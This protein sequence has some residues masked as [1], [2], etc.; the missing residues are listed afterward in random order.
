M[1]K[2]FQASVINIMFIISIQASSLADLPEIKYETFTLDNG[3]TV[4]VHEDKKVP[5]V[6]VN[7]WYHV[8]SKN[9]KLGKTGFAHL[10]EHLMFNGTEN[11]NN[12]YFEPF[13][14]IGSTDQNGTTNS[15]RTNYFQNVPTNALDLALWMESDRMGH[16]LGVVDQEKLDE[17]RGVVQNEKRQGENQPYGKA[18]TRIS[19]SAFPNGHP[20]SWSTIG[21]MDDLD[22]ASLEDVQDWFKTYY[23]PNNAV[24]ALAGD[25]DLETAKLKVAKYFG[26]IASG[27]PLVKPEK[28]IAKRSEEKR[29]V[30]FD[31]VPQARIY[32]IWNVPERDTE[33]AAHF[34][35][36]SSVLVGGKNSPLYKELVYEQQIATSVSSFYYDREIAGMFFIVAD[37]VAGVD[38][39][40]VETAM[41]DVMAEF[42]KRGPNPKLLKAE[43]TKILAGFIRGI[44]RIGGFGGKSDLLA[45]CQ[46]YTGD[47]GC[48]QKNLAYLDAVTPSKMK[49]TFAKW[50]DDTPYVL[51]ILPTDKYSVGE[52]DLDR[53]SGVPYPTEKVEFQFPTLQT[54]TLSNGAKV[55]LAQR[56]GVPLV[57]MNFQ[58][59]FG[60]AQENND[61]LG[62][63]NFMM[64]MLNEGTKKY[65]SLEFDEVLDSL[66]SNL[67][68]GS[69]LDT[70]VASLSSLK[71]NLSQTLDLAKEALINPTFPEKEIERIK[72]E[73]LAGIIQ[74]ENRPASIAYRNI[75]KL[76]YGE[77]HP[78]GKP[79]TGSGISETISSITRANIIDVHSRAINSAHLTFAVAGDIEMQELVNLLESKFGDWSANS[80]SDLKA[81]T[82]VELPENR[83]I[84]LIDK[85]N[86]QQS[87]I[88][89]GQ[90]LPPSATDEEI[91]IDYMNYAIGGSFT[92]RLNM[93][94]REDKS[95]S[96]GVRT[97]LGDAK[98]QR[99]MLV[100][101]PVQTDKTS[102]SMAEIVTEYADYLSTKPITQDELAKGKA[103]KT[104]RLPGQFETLGAL[105]GGVSGIV[106]YDR[107]LDYLNQLPALL[108]EPSL[109][110]VQAKAQ[111]YIKPN[112][113]TWLIVGDL[114][115]IEEPIRALDLGEVK[116]IK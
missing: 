100:T 59:N 20:Y 11:Y 41:D 5:M 43:K 28:W 95:W 25:I 103:S 92:A 114:S 113:W 62:Y 55:V 6:A 89:A 37:V 38:P 80:D 8:G 56:K 47:P 112:Q 97:R 75:G 51:T 9:E 36:A 54:A 39:A 42:T 4:I 58:F 34:D 29:E 22:A 84:Y 108:D 14:K 13:E 67:G 96:Y 74:E 93:N 49:A 52:T 83:T 18:F 3:L 33:A 107:D 10:F 21:S 64:G 86:A 70:S 76:L 46:T 81:L 50:I 101:A 66:G 98:G 2:L 88:V 104:L 94:L 63:T 23:G 1:N 69:G 90:L 31:D 85:P 60:Y 27:P 78:Y 32:K 72:K 115:K 45:T 44:Q 106:T 73:T 12:E 19:E 16:L 77:E 15:D 71:A 7:V 68:F 116:V 17:Q 26:D 91:E 99:A 61:E 105:K 40:T 65:S 57:E 35:L 30:M 48:Y 109:T 87:Y 111:K 82:T 102:E 79:L 24:L 53:S 110:Q